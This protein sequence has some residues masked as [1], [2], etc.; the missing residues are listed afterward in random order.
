MKRRGSSRGKSEAKR[1]AEY[2]RER[3]KR[4]NVPKALKILARGQE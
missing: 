1:A 2:F 4:G 3:A